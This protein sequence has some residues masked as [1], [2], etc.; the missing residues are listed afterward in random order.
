MKKQIVSR[1][2]GFL[3]DIDFSFTHAV[4]HLL[5]HRFVS[6][7]EWLCGNSPSFLY[8]DQVRSYEFSIGSDLFKFYPEERR[9]ESA[10]LTRDDILEED[11]CLVETEVAPEIRVW[12]EGLNRDVN[13]HFSEISVYEDSLQVQ[14][15]KYYL[16]NYLRN[17]RDLK[18]DGKEV[19]LNWDGV[20]IICNL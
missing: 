2:K 4:W 15:H 16:R 19:R 13:D 12:T 10:V 6:R 20:D 7:A 14:M 17:L 11:W 9:I 18:M 8:T 1:K 5:D 3:C